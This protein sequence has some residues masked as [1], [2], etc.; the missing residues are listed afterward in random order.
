MWKAARWRCRLWWPWHLSRGGWRPLLPPPLHG[1]PPY[2]GPRRL[3]GRRHP[4]AHATQRVGGIPSPWPRTVWA[5]RRPRAAGAVSPRPHRGPRLGVL[6]WRRRGFPFCLAFVLSPRRRRHT[7][8]RPQRLPPRP[9]APARHVC[10]R[11]L[12][13]TCGGG[14]RRSRRGVWRGGRH[15]WYG[16]GMT[17]CPSPLRLCLRPHLPPR[18]RRAAL[19]CPARPRGHPR[20]PRLPSGRT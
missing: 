5:W 8:R 15:Q 3:G 7:F 18:R 11:V 6:A 17:T 20:R 12:S 16:T 14:L 10:R 2:P 9:P 19:Q 1:P 4:C 13:P